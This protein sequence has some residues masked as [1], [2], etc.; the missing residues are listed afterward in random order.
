MSTALL[1]LPLLTIA[2]GVAI[3]LALARRQD[4]LEP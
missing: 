3:I 1:F 4:R 2:A